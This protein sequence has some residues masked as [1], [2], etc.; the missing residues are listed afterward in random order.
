[1]SRCE[2]VEPRNTFRHH[3]FGFLCAALLEAAPRDD[4]SGGDEGKD[5][6]KKAL[7]QAQV[8]LRDY[9]DVRKNGGSGADAGEQ[10]I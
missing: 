10:L 3:T 1:M 4:D 9:A 8:I 2:A 7:P 5:E 6:Q